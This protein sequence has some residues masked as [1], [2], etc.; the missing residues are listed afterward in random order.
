MKRISKDGEE[1]AKPYPTH[2]NLLILQDLWQDYY[3]ILLVILL[4]EFIKS[5]VIM[6]M[7]LKNVKLEQLNT[8]IVS[9]VLNKQTLR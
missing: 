7:V 8:K 4:K 5:N 3:Q 2:Y 1:T 9:A 6:N